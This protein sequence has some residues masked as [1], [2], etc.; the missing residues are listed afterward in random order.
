MIFQVVDLGLPEVTQIAKAQGGA[1]EREVE[2]KH[3]AERRRAAYGCR[4]DVVVVVAAAENLVVRLA[5]V[6]AEHHADERN[7]QLI[8]QR[9]VAL[10]QSETVFGNTRNH[11]DGDM[12]T[13][14]RA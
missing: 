10:P 5:V 13:D 3:L 1:A 7:A 8:A 11:F 9:I 6:G 12:F 2:C 14:M 4:N